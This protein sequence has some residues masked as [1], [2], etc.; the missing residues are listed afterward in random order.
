MTTVAFQLALLA[1]WR[2]DWEWKRLDEED[3]LGCNIPME[4]Q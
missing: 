1:V 4:I 3:W 2:L